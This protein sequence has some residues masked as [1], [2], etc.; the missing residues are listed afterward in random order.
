MES[1]TRGSVDSS[2]ICKPPCPVSNLEAAFKVDEGYSEDSR[3]LD[4]GDLVMGEEPRADEVLS[5]PFPS[6]VGLPNVVL[7]LSE[8][9]RIGMVNRF[10]YSYAFA[11][12][13]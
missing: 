5:M 11:E 8:A 6:L 2:Q 12:R 4:G 10:S 3:S 7:S 9:E 13:Y 1:Y